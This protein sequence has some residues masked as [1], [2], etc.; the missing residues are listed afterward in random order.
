[1]IFDTHAHYDDESFDA[2]RDALLA[3]LAGKGVG[4]VI[5]IGA[6]LQGARDSVALSE[7]YPFVYAAAGI[8]PD[9]GQDLNEA[10][11]EEIRVL[12]AHEKTVMIGEI[13]LDY[14]GFDRWPD[15]VPKETQKYWFQ[16]QLTLAEELRMPVCI[17][18]RNAAEDTLSMMTK[19]HEDGLVGGI[20]HCF[21]YSREIAEKYLSMGFFLGI[22][23]SLT[24]PGQK[25]L[26]KVLEAAPLTQILL[27]TDSPYL[28]PVPHKGER[29]NSA[30]LT[31]VRD[32]IAGIKGVTPEEVERVTWENAER[33]LQMKSLQ[34]R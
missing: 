16:R 9:E 2:D 10:A 19:A 33:L 8:H 22:G 5:N 30:Y 17:H 32:L 25:K 12:A 31:F 24:Y 21:S 11:M 29:N 34:Q 18:S 4:G 23:G 20:I 28:A 27:E 6:A 7:K 26:T 3:G 14:H 15:K 1:M 13:G